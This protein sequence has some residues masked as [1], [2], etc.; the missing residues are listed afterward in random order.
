MKKLASWLKNKRIASGMDVR[1]LSMQSFVATS[2]ISRVENDLSGMTVNTLVGLGYGLG[3]ELED[4]LDRLN[5][6]RTFIG[7]KRRRQSKPLI[8]HIGDAY[9]LWLLFRDEPQKAKSLM[10]DGYNQAQSAALDEENGALPKTLDVVWE[11]LQGGLNFFAPLPYPDVMPSTLFLEAYMCKAVLTYRDLGFAF[12]KKRVEFDLSQRELAKRT[13]ISHS[14]I[15]RLEGGI[16]ERVYFEYIVEIDDALSMDGQLLA[17]AWEVGEYES[18]IS[19]MKY[20]NEKSYL[21]Q[22]LRYTEWEQEAK[23]WADAFVTICRWHYVKKLP[24][25]WWFGVQHEIDFYKR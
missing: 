4:V 12:S 21:Q 22:K 17:M 10:Y 13:G 18:G 7:S 1:E 6:S 2:Q 8:P 24:H 9:S 11:A 19:L 25:D 3:F 20:I 5:I 14:V 23:A 16:L 15:S